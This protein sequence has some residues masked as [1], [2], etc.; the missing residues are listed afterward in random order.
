MFRSSNMKRQRLS[1]VY[2]GKTRPIGPQ[3][4]GIG[5]KGLER[6]RVHQV[7]GGKQREP[8]FYASDIEN[9]MPVGTF[10]SPGPSYKRNDFAIVTIFAQL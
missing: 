3:C 4:Y 6:V 1:C 5:S 7:E 2:H 10:N 8:L 9:A